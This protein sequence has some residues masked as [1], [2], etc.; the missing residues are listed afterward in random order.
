MPDSMTQLPAP[1]LV[2]LEARA[3]EAAQILRL[4]ANDRR[5]TLLCHLVNEG[6]V[7]VGRLTEI[8]GLAQSAVSQHLAKLREDGLVATRREGT[9]IHYRIDDPRVARI[10]ATLHEVFCE[11]VA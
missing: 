7:T 9:M 10:L 11:P 3:A 1:Q 2:D 6:E 4:L 5:L 8:L